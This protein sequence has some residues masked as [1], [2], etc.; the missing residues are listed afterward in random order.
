MSVEASE[1]RSLFEA[2][3]LRVFER[4]WLSSNNIL[5]V[6][7]AEGSSVL[8][9]TGYATHAEQTVALVS[10]ALG[11]RRLGRV[12]NTHL[13]SD[14]CGGNA[15]LQSA[16][17]CDVLVPSTSRAAVEQWDTQRL[18][19]DAIG[20]RCERFTCHAGLSDGETILLG[21]RRW[22][23]HGSPGHD[24]DSLV[25][26]QPE[27]RLLISA[28]ALW[29]NGFG[30]IFPE[31]EG[32]PG[33]DAVATTL[34]LIDSLDV[35]WVIPGHGAPF[36][37]IGLALSRARSRLERW[38]RDPQA[39]LRH[40]AKVLVKFRLLEVQSCSAEDLLAWTSASSVLTRLAADQGKPTEPWLQDVVADLCR[41][42]AASRHANRID[43]A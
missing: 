26:H 40:A 38:V 16:F 33:F 24:P 31:L 36:N 1:P 22:H 42:G 12:L 18:G 27:L 7:P 14:H 11:G 15:R 34:D 23:V 17:G 39:H 41:S 30:V 5:F 28:D 13:H 43:N 2:A 3:G 4:G 29:E 25:L 20:Q 9:D 37:D 21:G 35:A 6:D 8:V 32:V 19:F 10:N